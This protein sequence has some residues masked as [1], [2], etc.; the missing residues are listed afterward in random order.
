M[1]DKSKNTGDNQCP[2]YG[3][4]SLIVHPLSSTD[5]P[6]MA[7][8][9]G[10]RVLYTCIAWIVLGFKISEGFFLSMC[11]FALPVFMDCLKFT[12]LN[13]K[14]KKIIFVE[15][16]VSGILFVISVI[17]VIGIY[18][19][20][21]NDESWKIVTKNFIGFLP[22]GFDISVIW[23]L[24]GTVVIITMVDWFCNEAKIDK[25]NLKREE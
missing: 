20:E 17:G 25:I 1:K 11:F 21:K 6:N 7:A 9:L 5:N 3:K 4:C 8:H 13:K 19:L 10:F 16:F 2:L 15:T 23:Y 18:A 12:P 14:R 24:L 22:S